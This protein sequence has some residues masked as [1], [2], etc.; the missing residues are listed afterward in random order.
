MQ[1]VASRRRLLTSLLALS[2]FPCVASAKARAYVQRDDVLAWALALSEK[3]D[4]PYDWIVNALEKAEHNR[5]TA[6]IMSKPKLTATAK[7]K[8]WYAHKESILTIERTFMGERFLKSHAEAFERAY[9]RY[10]VAPAVI[11][12]IIGIESAYGRKMG[13]HRV[14]DAL[15]TLSFD[16]TRRETF[17]KN[18]LASF[19][20]WCHRSGLPA[21]QQLGSFAGAIG[22]CQF[23]PSN[24]VKLGVDFDNDGKV[25]LRHSPADAI[26][27][28]AHYLKKAGW[29]D[30]LPINWPCRVPDNA[31]K[32]LRSGGVRTNTTVK[33]A[34]ALGVRIAK[35][36][37]PPEDTP[38]LLA[39]LPII[40][41]DG[42]N[43]SLWRLGS[44]NYQAILSYNRSYFYAESVAELTRR[45]EPTQKKLFG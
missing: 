20:L 24:I 43:A 40:T 18:E 39:R 7:P 32:E 12:S 34:K 26:G 38:V 4:I 25:D 30:G 2:L 9:E 6:K 22:M 27:S 33:Q 23:M 29:L 10:G 13:Q 14:L 28:V 31:H 41:A 37:E 19:L 8:N 21:H 16:Y 35:D 1:F 5:T 15:M 3:N 42:K 44:R 17:F 36:I 45:L 11:A